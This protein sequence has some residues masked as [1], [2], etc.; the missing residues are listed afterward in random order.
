MK[1]IIF[2]VISA[3]L[4]VIV[5]NA[6]HEHHMQDTS[7]PG[8]RMADTMQMDH[9]NMD[10]K[11][12]EMNMESM[13]LMSDPFSL[14]LPMQRHGSGTAWLPDA[15]PMNAYMF[16]AKKWMYMLHGNLFLRYTNQDFS[17]KGIRGD[18][19]FDAP[20]WFM[21]MGQRQVGKNGLFHF[22]SM[23]S[24]DPITEGGEGYP[25]LFQSGETYN[26]RPL[27]DRQH[28]HDLFSEL[29]VSYSQ[30][31]SKKSDVF[32]YLAYPGEPALGPVAFMHRPSSLSNPDA[33][34]THHWIDATH[35]TFGVATLGVRYGDLKLEGSSFTG[36]EPDESR[37]GFDKPLFDS[38]SGRLSY[39]PSQHWALQ[40]SHGFIKNPEALHPDEDI[41]RTTASAIYSLPI[42]ND[43]TF[44][45]TAVW[46]MNKTPDHDGENAFLLEASWKKNKLTL[47]SRYE[48]VQK[49]V[50]EL[51]L[52]E[53]T[54]GH[55]TVFPVNAFTVGFHYDILEIGQTRLASGGQLSFYH[56]DK[57]LNSLYGKNPM[58]FEVY[59]RLY[60]GIIKP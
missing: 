28:P 31:L 56:A 37:Y 8:K 36:S 30:A 39:N 52:D 43:G 13:H 29:S 49:S 24:L 40:V 41:H 10:M 54:Y 55:D 58:A 19:K 25:L 46:G 59:L 44:N 33:P 5:V 14:N 47:H 22:S 35:I 27:I 42:I 53:N 6:Q 60:P 11:H 45:A 9:M 12:D 32:I 38:W 18:D 26:G 2:L 57:K 50:E 1:K 21:F 20:N 15:S 17:N 16:H 48:W 23:I 51:V 3:C 7:K 34:I 4:P